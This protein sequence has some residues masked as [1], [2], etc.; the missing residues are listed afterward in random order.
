[1]PPKPTLE[2]VGINLIML[3]RRLL[4]VQE[5]IVEAEELLVKIIS[6]VRGE[7]EDK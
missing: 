3:H 4:E 6:Q 2:Q 5:A 7:E 1:M